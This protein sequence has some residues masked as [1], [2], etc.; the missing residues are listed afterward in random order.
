MSLREVIMKGD[1]SNV[2]EKSYNNNDF[3]Q[4]FSLLLLNRNVPEEK[5]EWYIK[6]P[7]DF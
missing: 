2:K 5:T 1:I 4:K 3:R 6:S 7:V